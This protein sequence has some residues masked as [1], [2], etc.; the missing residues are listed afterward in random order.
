MK[1]SGAKIKS[2]TEAREMSEKKIEELNNEIRDLKMAEINREKEEL[3]VERNM[4]AGEFF[5]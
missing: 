1:W 5:E 2:E 3:E 4:L